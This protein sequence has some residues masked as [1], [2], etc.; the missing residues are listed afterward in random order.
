MPKQYEDY[1]TGADGFDRHPAFGMARI[2]RITA[3]PGAALF[4][5]DIRHG[6]YIEITLAEAE[7]KRDLK[8]D[9]VHARRTLVKFAMSMSQFASFVSSGGTEGIPVTIEYDHGDRPGLNLESRLALTTAEVRKAAREAFEDIKAAQKAYQQ[10]LADKAPAAVRNAALR[11][12][13]I[14]IA[15]A[16][17]NVDYASKQLTEHAEKVV[18]KSRADIE[19]MV[20]AAQQRGQVRELSEVTKMTAALEPARRK[21]HRF[22]HDHEHEHEHLVKHSHDHEHIGGNETH[23]HRH[24]G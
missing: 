14:A 12:V 6:E 5:S 22:S 1:V 16:E 8:H 4:Q 21:V 17:P 24:E 18:E 13:E 20:A 7:R 2:N 23:A 3:T 9:W 11:D 15:N 10:A 19:A